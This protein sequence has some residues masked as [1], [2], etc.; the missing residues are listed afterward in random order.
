MSA[1]LTLS[2]ELIISM[3][4]FLIYWYWKQISVGTFDRSALTSWVSN[5]N[6]RHLYKPSQLAHMSASDKGQNKFPA[7]FFHSMTVMMYLLYSIQLALSLLQTVIAAIFSS[8]LGDYL[9]VQVAWSCIYVSDLSAD[10]DVNWQLCD[11]PAGG[12]LRC[13]YGDLRTAIFIRMSK[14]GRNYMALS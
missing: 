6:N 4:L 10:A 12:L 8:A 5:S 1:L 7:R 3:K 2:C 14:Y 9:P 11:M 13:Y